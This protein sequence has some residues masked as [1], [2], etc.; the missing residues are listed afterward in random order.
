MRGF[1]EFPGLTP[2]ERE[3]FNHLEPETV[4]FLRKRY[5][6]ITR[7]VIADI[8]SRSAYRYPEKPALIY[9]DTTLTYS[10]LDEAIN[11]V[12]NGLLAL[13]L[14]RHGRV[15]I[16]AHNTVHHVMTW[17]GTAKAGG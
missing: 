5:N 2:Q 3:L 8:V 16:L 4:R 1:V 9:G 17:L 15:A 7:W 10:Q 11:R 6:Y 12:A 13:G 14:R